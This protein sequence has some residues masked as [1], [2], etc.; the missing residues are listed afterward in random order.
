MKYHMQCL[1]LNDPM[2]AIDLHLV[3][4]ISFRQKIPVNLYTRFCRAKSIFF[5]ATLIQIF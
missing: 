1:V 3:A 5:H 4:K 2:L